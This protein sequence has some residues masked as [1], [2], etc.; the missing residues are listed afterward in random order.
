M[1]RTKIIQMTSP[2]YSES[3][4]ETNSNLSLFL[5]QVMMMLPFW[6]SSD[7]CSDSWFSAGAVQYQIL[8]KAI[9]CSK[10]CA[11]SSDFSFLGFNKFSSQ[12]C[13]NLLLRLSTLNSLVKSQFFHTMKLYVQVWKFTAKLEWLKVTSSYWLSNCFAI[14]LSLLL[15]LLFILLLILLLFTPIYAIKQS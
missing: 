11:T 5:I 6:F 15:L 9:Q 10:H 2:K 13:E 7:L 4:V 3:I 14:S 8:H 12:I 1:C